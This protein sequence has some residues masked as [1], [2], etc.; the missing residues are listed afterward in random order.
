MGLHFYPLAIGKYQS[1]LD[2]TAPSQGQNL[3]LPSC[4]RKHGFLEPAD[5][6]G[7]GWDLEYRHFIVLCWAGN[8]TGF[9]NSLMRAVGLDA[10]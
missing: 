10:K 7:D 4:H 1:R 3:F 5:I 2:T 6:L 9:R 8:L